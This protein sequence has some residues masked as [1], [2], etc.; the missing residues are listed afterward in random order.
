MTFHGRR[1]NTEYDI[2]WKIFLLLICEA[3]V[4]LPVCHS[5]S[6]KFLSQVY[7][8]WFKNEDELKN[9]DDLKNEDNL[10]NEEDLK[11]EDNLKKENNPEKQDNLKE[12]E[13]V[14]K[15]DVKKRRQPQS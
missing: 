15:E 11:K 14:K 10:K 5:V 9:E 13:D 3:S 6:P 7:Q 4:I 2:R 12:E 8:V 1:L